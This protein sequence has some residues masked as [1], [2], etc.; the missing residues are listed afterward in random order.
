MLIDLAAFLRKAQEAFPD[1]F[2]ETK[3]LPG[4]ELELIIHTGHEVVLQ[5]A[6]GIAMITKRDRDLCTREVVVNVTHCYTCGK[7]HRLGAGFCSALPLDKKEVPH[8]RMEPGDLAV[9]TGHSFCVLCRRIHQTGADCYLAKSLDDVK[10][11][12][13]S[14]TGQCGRLFGEPCKCVK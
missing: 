6:H 9:L 1:A 13:I 8:A 14:C 7:T 11:M 10:E 2:I 4:E 12:K 5:G 3:G